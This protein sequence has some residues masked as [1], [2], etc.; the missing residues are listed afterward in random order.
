MSYFWDF[1]DGITSTERAPK[2]TYKSLEAEYSVSLT[3]KL[4]N[5]RASVT[6]GMLIPANPKQ[7]PSITYSENSNGWVAF[8]CTG[9]DPNNAIKYSWNFGDGQTQPNGI[10][11]ASCKYSANGPYSV[12]CTVTYSNTNTEIAQKDIYVTTISSSNGCCLNSN[13]REVEKDR[14]T[15]TYNG[16]D[17]R[18]KQ[19]ARITNCFGFHRLVA[20]TICQYN[21]KKDTWKARKVELIN[22]GAEGIIYKQNGNCG[23]GCECYETVDLWK[24]GENATDG[25][26]AN[27]ARVT[28]DKG[29]GGIAFAVGKKSVWARHYVKDGTERINGRGDAAIHDDACK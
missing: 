7:Q 19:V 9:T 29:T 1:G 14:C 25:A 24:D 18:V 12:K 11:M 4:N 27:A 15:Y 20:R 3:V 5:T 17:R 2:H 13:D 16:E 22:A 26:I 8:T 6:V 28:M 23:G 10:N 21:K